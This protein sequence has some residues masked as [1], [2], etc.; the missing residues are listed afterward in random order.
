MAPAPITE[1]AP[2]LYR[3]DLGPDGF[4][5]GYLFDVDGELTLFDAGFPDSVDLVL[6]AIKSLARQPGELGRII[7]SHAHIDHAGSVRELREHTGA[8]VLMSEIDAELVRGG[9]SSRGLKIRPG[10]EEIVLEQTGGMDLTVPVPIESFEV[11]GFVEPGGNVPGIPDAE[12]IATP[13]HC[14][15]QL[16]LLWH[17]HGGVLLT[18]DAAANIENELGSPPVAEDFELQS[19]TFASLAEREFA[20]AAFGH[21]PPITTDAP[22]AFRAVLATA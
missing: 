3:L 13:G 7:V 1:I 15:G 11:S 20:I 4:V 5:N 6:E 16:S 14:A 17:R 2:G 21:G 10:F 12:L 9:L 8:P 19:A 18:A 22:G